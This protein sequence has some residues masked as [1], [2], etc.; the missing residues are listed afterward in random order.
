MPTAYA[1]CNK[2]FL[3]KYK[4]SQ[5]QRLGSNAFTSQLLGKRQTTFFYPIKP[6]LILI[7]VQLRSCKREGGNWSPCVTHVSLGPTVDAENEVV[8][9]MF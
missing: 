5:D 3:I 9:P 1:C 8:L 6:N 7:S 4:Q 2:M